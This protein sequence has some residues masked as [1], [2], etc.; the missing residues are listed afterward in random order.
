L[1]KVKNEQQYIK[2]NLNGEKYAF[3]IQI[4][5]K[6]V[7]MTVLTRVPYTA[8]YFMGITNLRGEILSIVNLK[9]FLN[10]AQSSPKEIEDFKLS[11]KSRVKE[12]EERIIITNK[13]SNLLGFLVDKV[14]GVETVKEEDLKKPPIN[15]NNEIADYIEHI[16]GEQDDFMVILD[17]SMI[18]SRIKFTL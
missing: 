9:S 8:P 5:H 2:F 6:I 7:P 11:D 17:F 14:Y 3:S 4:V 18:L 12:L 16:Y 13:D 10:L 1:N 15:L